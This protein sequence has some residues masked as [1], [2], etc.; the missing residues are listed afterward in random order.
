MG[1]TAILTPTAAPCRGILTVA[2]EPRARLALG[3]YDLAP[4]G[5]VD[6]A[7]DLLSHMGRLGTT[8][9]VH[10][11]PAGGYHDVTHSRAIGRFW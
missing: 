6:P 4:V 5:P 7:L 1:M 3:L 9:A 11:L 10:D 2:S 8:L